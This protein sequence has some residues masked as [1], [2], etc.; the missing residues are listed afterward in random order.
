MSEVFQE[1]QVEK[2]SEKIADQLAALIKDGKLMPGDKLPSERQLI[3]LLGVGRSSLREAL[4][5]LEILGYVEIKKRKGIYVKSIGKTLQLDPLKKVIEDDLNK[6]IQLYEIR[7]DIE[8]ANA[9]QAAL[10]RS[11]ENIEEMKKNL[12]GLNPS[13]GTLPHFSWNE[14]QQF[15]CSIARATQ[16]IFRIHVLLNI[17]DFSRD[18]IQ[19]VIENFG[20]VK[21]NLATLKSHHYAILEAIENKDPVQAQ[22][23]MKE[24]LAWTNQQFVF[25]FNNN[26]S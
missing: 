1:I 9:F 26:P 19:A 24:H 20:N 10:N 4:N 3:D 7:S 2:V 12:E 5:R 11:E 13:S 23:I 14:D 21:D 17:F 22:K 25:Y 8:Q 16:N 15:H 18:L 6:I